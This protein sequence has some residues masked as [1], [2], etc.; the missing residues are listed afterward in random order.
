MAAGWGRSSRRA[1]PPGGGAGET[2]PG[3]PEQ[4]LGDPETVA[5]E[6]CLRLL[7]QR[8]RSRAELVDALARRGVPADATRRV[9]DRF[10]E[11]GLVDDA[12]M[13]ETLAAGQHRER[14]LARRA[15]AA[16]LRQ[17]GLDDEIVDAAVAGIDTDRERARARQLVD[18]RRR[19]LSG[20]PGDV[21]VRRLVSLL[22]RKGYSSGLAYSVVRE[23]L[24]EGDSESARQVEILDDVAST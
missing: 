17:R 1:N 20:L 14:G 7:T 24:A 9:L 4:P 2:P 8:A 6:I 22:A 15:V 5:R 16:K 13:A 18:Q 19:T 12:A 23:A 21:Q 3:D 11:V 10:T